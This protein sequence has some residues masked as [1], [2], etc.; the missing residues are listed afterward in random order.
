MHAYWYDFQGQRY[1]FLF[2]EIPFLRIKLRINIAEELSTLNYSTYAEEYQSGGLCVKG[3]AWHL[4]LT[5]GCT[6]QKHP[7]PWFSQL[8]SFGTMQ[9]AHKLKPLIHCTQDFISATIKQMG[10]WWP[11]KSVNKC[12][13]LRLGVGLP[14]RLHEKSLKENTALWSI[15]WI[16]M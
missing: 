13:C 9:A 7:S 2:I 8:M 1:K 15:C 3:T 6:S 11:G 4:V 16:I 5:A 14:V 10:L 12:L